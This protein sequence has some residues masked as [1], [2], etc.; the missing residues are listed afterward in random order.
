MAL[1][2]IPNI[3]SRKKVIFNLL[4][5]TIKSACLKTRVLVLMRLIKDIQISCSAYKSGLSSSVPC[6]YPCNVRGHSI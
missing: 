4:G 5:L 6:D 2:C 1:E 3:Y